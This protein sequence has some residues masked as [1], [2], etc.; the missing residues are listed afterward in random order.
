MRH[1]TITDS[2]N[3]W[4]GTHEGRIRWFPTRDEVVDYE[5]NGDGHAMA[6][7]LDPFRDGYATVR[8]VACDW[9]AETHYGIHDAESVARSKFRIFHL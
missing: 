8:C 7:D 9:S 1:D 3:P 4:Y 5:R 6:L 2:A